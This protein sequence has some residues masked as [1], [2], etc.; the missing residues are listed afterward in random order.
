MKVFYILYFTI[1]SFVYGNALTL[2]KRQGAGTALPSQQCANKDQTWS[3]C[4]PAEG[5]VWY[6]GTYQQL[7]W[8]YNHPVFNNFT[9]LSFYILQKSD[10][11]YKEIKKIDVEHALGVKVVLIDDSWYPSQ[12]PPNSPNVS[13]PVYG[14]LIGDSTN[15]QEELANS[16]SFFPKPISFTLIENAHN[17][18]SSTSL[19]SSPTNGESTNAN[20]ATSSPSSSSSFPGWAIA[21]IVIVVL[22]IIAAGLALFWLL[23]KI[24]KNRQQQQSGALTLPD[25]DPSNANNAL[26]SSSNNL[27]NHHLSQESLNNNSNN[28]NNSTSM[29][30]AT[31]SNTIKNKG[32]VNQV[33]QIETRDISSSIHSSTPM[34]QQPIN[35]GNGGSG[36]PTAPSP[37]SVE[38]SPSIATNMT[39]T[40]NTTSPTHI[41]HHGNNDH[42]HHPQQNTILSSTD[43]IMIAD[44]FRQLM[45]KPDWNEHNNEEINS[46]S[47]LLKESTSNDA[48]QQQKKIDDLYPNNES[49]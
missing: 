12:L 29:T 42:L 35:R 30:M 38:R 28:N 17:T 37:T 32:I 19:A 41:L 11:E 2:N 22:L 9:I 23:R 16:Q 20:G 39:S 25:N 15:L 40:T 31:S 33:Q 4:S 13:I 46:E 36:S 34:M 47:S 6:N 10:T 48:L 44:T 43:A 24:R 5:D 7:T 8:K 21:V 3:I 18:T 14:Y 45:R 1:L 27:S 26:L 49:R